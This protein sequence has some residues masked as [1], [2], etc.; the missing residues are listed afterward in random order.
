MT[1]PRSSSFLV[2][3]R[4][5]YITGE[6][7]HVN[8]G[9]ID[10]V[11]ASRDASLASLEQ[12]DLTLSEVT[13]LVS[14]LEKSTP[15]TGTTTFGLS[16]NVTIDLLGT[17]LRKRAVIQGSRADV[18]SGA[19][20]DHLGNV[21]RFVADGVDAIIVLDLF[22]AF[23]PAFEARIDG[24]GPDQLLA[25]ADRY[26]SELAILLAEARGVKDVFIGGMHR[27]SLPGVTQPDAVDRAVAVFNDVIEEEAGRFANVHLISTASISAGLG[28]G[29]A[30]DD[31]SYERFRAPFTPAFLDEFA[32]EV[33]YATRGFGA[34][35]YKALVLDCDGTLWGGILGED[36][37]SGIKLGPFGYPGSMYWRMQ[38]EFLALQRHGVL[39]CLCSKNDAADVDEVLSSHPDMVLRDEHIVA[40]RVNWDDKVANL[41]S[42]ASDLNIG[43]D[44]MV[45]VDDSAFECEAVRGRLPMVR[46]LQVPT[47]LSEYPDL[48]TD[49]RRLFAIG[50]EAGDGAAKTEQYRSRMLA[51]DERQRFVD[52]QEY[53]ES[54]GLKVTIRRNDADSAQRI[55]ELT[56]KSNQF[57]LT[58]HRYSTSQIDDPHGR[59]REPTSTRSTSLTSSAT[60]AHRRCD[61]PT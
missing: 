38:H 44:S 31:R 43:L 5:D 10:P 59:Q 19:F 57:N 12:R 54:L 40:K 9:Q 50:S 37:L 8:G 23:L 55:A 20:G 41:E 24:L 33:Y 6:T 3:D 39:L 47:D 42:L 13:K 53:L 15:S 27:L 4:A 25:Q 60:R 56:Q 36:Q 48:A 51:S 61:H 7:I 34:Y 11:N 18:R 17:Y 28:S 16:G 29:A 22:D 1:S 35:F 49:L 58:T 21:R 45:F 2:S 32:G 14:E 30:H 46:T 26:R 52:Q